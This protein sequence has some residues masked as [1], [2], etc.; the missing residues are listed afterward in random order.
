MFAPEGDPRIP[1]SRDAWG[2][3]LA[4]RPVLKKYPAVRTDQP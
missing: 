1:M 4:K 2:H 3:R